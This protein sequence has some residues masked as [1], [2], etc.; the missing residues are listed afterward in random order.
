MRCPFC[1]S[2]VPND[3]LFCTFCGNNIRQQSFSNP[4]PSQPNSPY[5]LYNPNAQRPVVVDDAGCLAMFI[6]FIVP[7]IG[8]ALYVVWRDYRPRS[9]KTCLILALVA[10][11][12]GVLGFI[13]SFIAAML[14]AEAVGDF[15]NYYDCIRCFINFIK[16]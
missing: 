9:A 11:G 4:S 7:F 13:T 8:L 6:S 15:N 1:N 3:S 16:L 5:N 10:F 12:L 2:E 14:A